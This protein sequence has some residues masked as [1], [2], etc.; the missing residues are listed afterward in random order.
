MIE[1]PTLTP[2]PDQRQLGALTERRWPLLIG[3]KEQEPAS[4]RSYATYSPAT[5]LPIATVPDADATDVRLAVD[6]AE[7]ALRSWRATP[8][9]ERASLVRGLA[10]VLI[11]HEEEL[12]YLDAIDSG[13]PITAM[14]AD[15]RGAADML[16]LFADLCHA[17]TGS[18]IP[19]SPDTFHYTVLEPWGL[20]GCIIPYN[21]PLYFAAA[22]LAAPLVAG[23]AVILKPAPQTP[24]S[25]LRLGELVHEVMPAGLVTVLTGSTVEVA[26]AIVRHPAIRRISFTGSRNAGLA[27]QRAAA[28]SAVK[29]VTLEL[30]GKNP[31]VIFPDADQ[32]AAVAAVVKGMNLT[33]TGGQ[34]CGST[35][36]VF[37]HETLM[38][39]LL[40]RF[41]GLFA[42]VRLGDPTRPDTEMGPQISAAHRDRVLAAVA[43]AQD[44]GARVLTGG[45]PPGDLERGYYVQPT[46][47][48][49][50]QPSMRVAR[51]EIFGPVLS[52]LSFTAEADVLATTN[53]LPYGLTAGI[54]TR[55]ISRALRFA[56][57]VESGFVCV[58]GALRHYP[59]VPFGGYKDSGIGR[60]EGLTELLD[61]TQT[62]AINVTL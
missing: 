22:K 62:K 13:N 34:S 10:D 1:E 7:A 24:L 49:E 12:A 48:S 16:N 3:G 20:V 31:L 57:E 32:D 8:A 51:E 38:D 14:R 46:V 23:N 55:D 27:V 17:L 19:V 58:N 44:D 50:V 40:P 6:A 26:D 60:E 37:V 4:G 5:E 36:R 25:A 29:F 11:A 18:T 21:H 2:D 9:R 56:S 47:L 28:E 39:E 61:F 33:S 54:W 59:G 30:G 45:G 35:S 15:V 43:S 53:E 42:K 41:T 52:V